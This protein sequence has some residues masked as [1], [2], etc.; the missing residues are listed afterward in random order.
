MT[1]PF[2]KWAGGKSSIA[3]LLATRFPDKIKVYWEPFCGSAALFFHMHDRI[4]RAVLSDINGHLCV[5]Y[6]EVKEQPHN[7][8]DTL[9]LMAAEHHK[10]DHYYY[11]VRDHMIGEELRQDEIA[12]R[13]I[14]L[15]KTCFNGLW[16]ENKS[17]RHNVPK[18]KYDNPNIVNREGIYAAHEALQI[19]YIVAGDA[20]SVANEFFCE[21]T[22]PT[23]VYIDPPYAGGFTQY[24]RRGFSLADQ[25][26]T[27]N[28]AL[29]C[30][31]AGACVVVSNSDHLDVQTAYTAD[32]FTRESLSV[33]RHISAKASGRQPAGELLL[34]PREDGHFWV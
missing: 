22:K 1:K 17:G 8:I 26:A 5:A 2:L 15:N 33:P 27:A 32:S 3:D 16:R 30:R 4:E 11:W 25:M 19:A 18:G 12:A 31:K 6:Q 13:V 14:Y 10:S 23:A 9:R 20:W 21:K 29:H 24:N 34:Y 28:L 7:V